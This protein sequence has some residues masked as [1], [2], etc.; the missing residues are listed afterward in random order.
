MLLG[1]MIM[2]GSFGCADNR[3]SSAE[4]LAMQE[5]AEKEATPTTQPSNA[6]KQ[7]AVALIDAQLGAYKV[8]PGD[9]LIV[10]L[11][12]LDQPAGFAP[13]NIRVTRNGD[14]NLPSVAAIKVAGLELEDVEKIIH[15]A[16]V[17]AVYKDV[18]VHVAISEAD[19]TN[20]LVH[21]A[22]MTPGMVEL[23]RTRRNL[24]YAMVGAGGVTQIASG[25]VTLRRIRRPSEE[26]TLNL[27]NP[28]G[29]TAA[30][31]LDPLENGDIVTI[32]AATPNTVFVGGLVK[33]SLP[34]VYPP[35]TNVTVLQAI[36]AAGGLRTDVTPREATLI[37]RTKDGKDIQVKL[38]M[39]RITR[40][41]D[42]NLV[43]VAGDVLW[44][45]DTVETVVQ[46]WINQNVYFKF[47]GSANVFYDVT[48]VEYL[49]RPGQQSGG[50]IGGGNSPLNQ[51]DPFFFLNQSQ[52]IRNLTPAR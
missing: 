36:A 12:Q 6:A 29:L 40:G 27:T 15:D 4:F 23:K 41:Q 32:Q 7:E 51:I 9:V 38:N 43:L 52:A 24:L 35:G 19:M 50:N 20:V 47:G 30:L 31:A 22:A 1:S 17:P 48:G 26:V 21:G 18:A 10:S 39:D 16:Y 5:E 28:N 42:P 11:T 44:V 3:I 2:A 33:S 46:N 37:R 25:E 13:L 14:L 45:P 34:Q 49:N 8:G